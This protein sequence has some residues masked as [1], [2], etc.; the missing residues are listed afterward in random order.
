MLDWNQQGNIWWGALN[1]SQQILTA[2]FPKSQPVS[3][4]H[5]ML[6]FLNLQIV[7]KKKTSTENSEQMYSHITTPVWS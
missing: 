5:A 7:S 1:F 3:L 4:F 2:S 6:E